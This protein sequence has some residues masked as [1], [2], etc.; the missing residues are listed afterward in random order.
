MIK[1]QDSKDMLMQCR[2]LVRI[3]FFALLMTASCIG[4][5][6]EAE[7]EQRAGTVHSFLEG[8]ITLSAEI[9]SVADY[10]GFEIL[11]AERK[12][13][14]IDTLGFAQTDV[15]GKFSMEITAP[16]T[17]IYSLVISR[18]GAVLRLDEIAVAEGDSASFKV[19][20]PFGN[21]PVMIRSKENAA[22]LGFKNT[23]ALHNGEIDSYTRQGV[24]DRSVYANKI[25]LT[26]QILWGLQES[27]QGTLAASLAAAQSI[28]MLE[29]WND[30][31]VVVRAETL[32]PENVNYGLVVGAARRSKVR[33]AG[34][35]SGP[36]FVEALKA[37]VTDEDILAVI[38]SELVL[39]Y[40]DNDLDNE[41]LTAARELK[42]Q[43][44]TDSS[45]IRWA[46]RA[47]Y[48]LEYLRPG[49]EAPG[50]NLTDKSGKEVSPTTLAGK[51]FVLE[52][53]LPGGEF[54]I[55][56]PARNAFY[57]S[58]EGATPFEI[59][60]LSLNDDVDMNEAFFDGRD[61][62]GRH[63]ILEDG[64]NAGVVK[65]YNVYLLPTRF[66]IDAEG[67]IVGKYVLNNWMGA[68]QDALELTM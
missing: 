11:V 31:L 28:M 63:V 18:A 35:E 51:P 17:N 5:G 45:W 37:K 49:M 48:D 67:K 16:G 30:S 6:Q 25:F 15:E 22:L 13:E 23:V 57:R 58:E 44:A 36:A 24:E 14:G 65:K 7:A 68:F 43:Y 32:D 1:K 21:R 33:L 26:S 50:F 39:A 60:S 8:Q 19:K 66:L 62:P 12:E 29:G 61:I 41:A 46:D 40:R 10:S 20:F 47:I 27:S 34:L 42:M 56:L 52:F 38:Q 4:C 59:L 53:Y 54:E 64:P 55:Q 3:G 2:E 9:D